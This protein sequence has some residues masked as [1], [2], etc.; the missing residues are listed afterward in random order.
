MMCKRDGK[1]MYF[2]IESEKLSDGTRRLVMYYR[3]P[4]CGYRVEVEQ[5]VIKSGKDSIV[6]KRLLRS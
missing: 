1:P 4:V 2:V 6:V 3:C 5:V